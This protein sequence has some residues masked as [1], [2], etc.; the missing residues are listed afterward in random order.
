[1]F[2]GEKSKRILLDDEKRIKEGKRKLVIL[3]GVMVGLAVFSI[4]GVYYI[5]ITGGTSV[6]ESLYYALLLS[7]VLFIPLFIILIAGY[8]Y[9]NMLDKKK[10][11]WIV[12]KQSLSDSDVMGIKV[13]R[14]F[15]LVIWKCA[16]E[17]KTIFVLGFVCRS[18]NTLYL[19]RHRD[20]SEEYKNRI[21]EHINF[22][23]KNKNA[24]ISI[25]EVESDKLC[26]VRTKGLKVMAFS[27]IFIGVV[28]VLVVI[29]YK[30]S[31]VLFLK[32]AGIALG[33]LFLMSFLVGLWE[34]RQLVDTLNELLFSGALK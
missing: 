31:L 19:R 27:G 29:F 23:N 16:V 26:A 20:I 8:V 28:M 21:V 4:V 34:H 5:L 25:Y 17:S 9:L 11:N 33:T 30:V 18:Q 2:V 13:S 22:L 32:L 14:L 6:S 3:L 10:D 24:N 15:S 1:M 7:S 12:K